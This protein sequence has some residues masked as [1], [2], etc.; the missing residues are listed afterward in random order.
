MLGSQRSTLQKLTTTIP[1]TTTTLGYLYEFL[2]LKAWGERISTEKESVP[3]GELGLYNPINLYKLLAHVLFLSLSIKS[4]N[5]CH[6]SPAES[7]TPP[8]LC[9]SSSLCLS[10]QTQLS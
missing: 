2:G 4:L 7:P 1:V 3:L 8:C 9:S 5:S 6:S 10:Y